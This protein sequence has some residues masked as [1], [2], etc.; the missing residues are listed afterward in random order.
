MSRTL[1]N[2]GDL[3]FQAETH[4]YTHKGRR[5]KSVTQIIQDIGFGPD[6]SHADKIQL[7]YARQRGNAVDTA[8][9]YH[10]EGD[11]DPR[12]VDPAIRNYF[13][14]ALRFDRECP[15]EIVSVHPRLHSLEL[16][17]A[18]TPDLIR[19]VRGRRAVI[20]WKTGADNPLQTCMYLLLWNMAHPYQPCYE[21]YGLRLRAS[22]RYQLKIHEDPD[23]VSACMAIL[24]GN[25]TQISAWRM[26]YGH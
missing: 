20:D 22:G 21:R 9:V 4:T 14:A 6:F 3:L 8:L 11:L 19:F 15:G 2:D 1:L 17:I 24:S 16:G 25:D 13:E 10:Y 23:D 26:K 12:S 7:E 5:L 18:G